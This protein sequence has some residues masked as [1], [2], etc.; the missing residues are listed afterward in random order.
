[1][2][3][4]DNP[5]A[6]HCYILE[7]NVKE[8]GKMT[9]LVSSHLNWDKGEVFFVHFT[10]VLYFCGPTAWT[11]AR[12]E[13]APQEEADEMLERLGVGANEGDGAG[14][15]LYRIDG[16]MGEVKILAQGYD[17]TDTFERAPL[18]HKRG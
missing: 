1:M 8:R 13:E 11:S 16:P 9:L 12:L 5:D 7:L 4:I 15:R 17:V 6:H 3:G 2:L 18:P 10:G 14:Y